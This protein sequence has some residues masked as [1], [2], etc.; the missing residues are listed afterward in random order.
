MN[1]LYTYIVK[2]DSGLAPNPFGG[3]CTLA[4]CTP[5]HQGSAVKP[6]DWIAGFSPKEAGY[7][8]IYAMRVDE[9][10]H[11]N[12]YFR[13]PRF[14]SKRPIMSGGWKQKCGDN[15]YYQDEKGNWHQ[16]PNPYH[17]GMM[18]KD[19]RV[20]YVF[21]GQEF[22]YLGSARIDVP[23]E[24][25]TMVGGRSARVNHPVGLPEKFMNWVRSKFSLGI[26][27]EPLDAEVDSCRSCSPDASS[28]K[29]MTCKNA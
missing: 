15:F 22:W 12:E 24:Y 10:I 20:P 8:F 3:W 23:E 7:Q 28:K 25:L 16:L 21:V 11:M 4:V 27:A 14:E 19:T 17:Q 1:K 29:S 6:G 18:E 13:D 9:R 26:K 5:N 2:I